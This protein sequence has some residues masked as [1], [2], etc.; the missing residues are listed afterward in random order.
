V[1]SRTSVQRR[2]GEQDQREVGAEERVEDT[3]DRKQKPF[4]CGVVIVESQAR[5]KKAKK[6]QT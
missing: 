5:G 4:F 3:A 1:V 6:S 2:V